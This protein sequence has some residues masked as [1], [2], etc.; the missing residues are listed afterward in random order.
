MLQ[1]KK[2]KYRKLQKGRNKGKAYKGSLVQFGAYGLKALDNG[3]ITPRQIEAA[4]KVISRYTKKTGKL[5]IRIFPDIPFT[6]HAAE[7]K[8]G[9]G[10]GAVE[11]YRAKIKAGRILFE[12]EGISEELAR[13]VFYVAGSKLPLR[14]KFV[15][16]EI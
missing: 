6:K 15:T 12:I 2:T 7:T 4:R 10:K 9:K 11:G 13:K 3:Y 5:W 16:N 1:P 14:T 8:L